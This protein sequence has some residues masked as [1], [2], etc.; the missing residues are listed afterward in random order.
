MATAAALIMGN[1]PR[2]LNRLTLVAVGVAI[3]ILLSWLFG[4]FLRVR[5]FYGELANCL[6]VH[7]RASSIWLRR[8]HP[9]QQVRSA[10][11][12][13]TLPVR[14]RVLPSRFR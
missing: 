9:A 7:R 5:L 11:A 8:W 4:V 14:C 6:R 2:A 13:M 10:S 1:I 12:A 3:V